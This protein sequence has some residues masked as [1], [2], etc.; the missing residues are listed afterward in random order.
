M[1]TILYITLGCKVNQYE[2]E[3][4]RELLEKEGFSSAGENDAPDI[5]ILNSSND[6]MGSNLSNET[7]REYMAELLKYSLIVVS[8]LPVIIMYLFVQK[9]LVKG[10]MLGA[11]KG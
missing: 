5:L 3:A 6:A 9:H 1:K 4:I 7:Q 2:T 11:V 10:I 8:S